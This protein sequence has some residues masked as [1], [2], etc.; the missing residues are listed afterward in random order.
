M[1]PAK[2]DTYDIMGQE[3]MS[4][5][6]NP[7]SIEFKTLYDNLAVASIIERLKVVLGITVFFFAILI[8][9]IL[10]CLKVDD[11]SG[12]FSQTSWVL[13]LTPTWLI[14]VLAFMF[15]G[16]VILYLSPLLNSE[17][18]PSKF[19]QLLSFI[20]L[21]LFVTAQVF[22]ALKFDDTISW[23]Y[24][25]LFIPI[26]LYEFIT[27]A[28][29][30][31]T[32]FQ[33]NKEMGKMVTVAFVENEI[34]KSYSDMSAEERDEINK[35]YIIV[36]TP[37]VPADMDDKLKALIDEMDVF[38]SPEFQQAN[39][40]SQAATEKIYNIIVHVIFL[41]LLVPNL[42]SNDIN[43]NWWIV[44]IPIWIS[45]CCQCT[46]NCYIVC[47]TGPSTPMM[48]EIDESDSKDDFENVHDGMDFED[49]E[50]QKIDP[51]SADEIEVDKEKSQSLDEN[52][53]VE[54]KPL[55]KEVNT[56]SSIG[57]SSIK[58]PLS[59]VQIGTNQLEKNGPISGNDESF[60]SEE[61]YQD[62]E[63]VHESPGTA[64]VESSAVEA[65]A[66]ALGSCCSM[67]FYL[68]MVC[69]FVGK[70]QGGDGSFSAFWVIVPILFPVSLA[71]FVL[72]T[73]FMIAFLQTSFD[74]YS[75]PR[76]TEIL[77]LNVNLF[78]GWVFLLLL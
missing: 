15:L 18:K 59:E 51:Q 49:V 11:R 8:Q 29:A 44:F 28:Q 33:S 68:T 36:H 39:K 31:H 27:F 38:E 70:L 41:G 3:A 19:F 24:A 35:K 58:S 60:K 42:D 16:I 72:E 5:L 10:I 32:R 30:I 67:I 77:F 64:E 47:C 43:W 23:S 69:L 75:V 34:G 74:K 62:Y 54:L 45:F 61:S 57:N 20:K 4:Y 66:Q 53:D 13:L 14:D 7:S 26:Y 50:M 22:L 2:R 40:V 9:P 6:L 52:I 56:E 76:Y 48:E 12:V 21:A 63:E 1:D 71:Q 46:K 17:S 73:S 65:T 78:K 37:P 25:T 55:Q